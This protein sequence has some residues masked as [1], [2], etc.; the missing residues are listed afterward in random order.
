[1]RLGSIRA[2]DIVRYEGTHAFVTE[3]TQEN[4]RPVLVVKGIIN[5][6]TRRI[7]ATQVEAIWKRHPR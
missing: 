2:G 4:G 5:K 1:M 3:R 6:S 7:R